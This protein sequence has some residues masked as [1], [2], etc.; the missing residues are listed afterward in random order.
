MLVQIPHCHQRQGVHS[1]FLQ[2]LPVCPIR[3]CAGSPYGG[4]VDDDDDGDDGDNEHDNVDFA[5]PPC[6]CAGSW[7][8]SLDL[9][10]LIILVGDHR[11][12][13]DNGWQKFPSRGR[14]Q[15]SC[16]PGKLIL[17]S[18]SDRPELIEAWAARSFNKQSNTSH[19]DDVIL[20]T[21]LYF[22][23]NLG[24]FSPR[25]LYTCGWGNSEMLRCG[26]CLFLGGGQIFISKS[27]SLTHSL[28]WRDETFA[29]F[30]GRGDSFFRIN[31]HHYWLRFWT[32][33]KWFVIFIPNSIVALSGKPSQP[34]QPLLK[35]QNMVHASLDYT[36]MPGPFTFEL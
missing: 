13:H 7:S 30:W 9:T 17:G 29:N 11:V 36:L 27:A 31:A 18:S 19:R 4:E 32:W 8:A 28:T 33:G 25:R 35:S 22:I 24:N 12:L 2:A 26:G 20:F 21:P 6:A 1:R 10:S 3:A 14:Q 16:G 34:N 5:A 23:H 15:A